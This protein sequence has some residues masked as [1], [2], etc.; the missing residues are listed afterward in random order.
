MKTR[1]ENEDMRREARYEAHL[2]YARI[3]LS[4]KLSPTHGLDKHDQ[5][6]H[7]RKKSMKKIATRDKWE[8]SSHMQGPT[9]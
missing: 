9:G 3:L 1:G 5:V 6:K 2:L 8:H 7:K 4:N